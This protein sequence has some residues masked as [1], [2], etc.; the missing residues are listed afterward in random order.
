MYSALLSLNLHVC[1]V[2]LI[3]NTAGIGLYFFFSVILFCL[4]Y[5][6]VFQLHSFYS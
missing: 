2:V 6:F 4:Q 1:V 3:Q 5:M